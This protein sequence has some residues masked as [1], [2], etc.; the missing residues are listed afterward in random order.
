MKNEKE[1][2]AYLTYNY[3]KQGGEH[4]YHPICASGKDACILHYIT[5]NKELKRGEL[6]L[7]DSG[8]E[9]F[10]YKTD[11]SR[12]FPLSGKYTKRQKEVYDAVLRVQD[13]AIKELKIGST[14]KEYERAVR[15]FLAKELLKL[16]VITE[17][18]YRKN[19]LEATLAI[20]PHSTGHH[21]GLDTHDLS[22]YEIPLTEGMLVTVEPGIYLKN[23]GISIRIEDDI[24]I[25]KKGPVNLSKNI[26]KKIEEIS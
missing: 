2:E 8:A 4:S 12:T 13:F 14:K 26:P 7:I 15:G 24:L 23:E 22:T 18:D 16:K 25:T 5:N 3:V 19:P 1:V 6:L 9:L 17:E 11:I 10:G 20:Y 21:L